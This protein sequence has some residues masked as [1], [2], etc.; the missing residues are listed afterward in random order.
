MYCR[1]CGGELPD[2]A[3]YCW[4]C[5]TVQVSVAA[6]TEQIRLWSPNPSLTSAQVADGSQDPSPPHAPPPELVASNSQVPDPSHAS[7]PMPS[8]QQTNDSYYSSPPNYYC[9]PCLNGTPKRF[10]Q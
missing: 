2:Q 1:K 7:E 4:Y 10:H 3:S 6:N 8:R 9:Q 5:G